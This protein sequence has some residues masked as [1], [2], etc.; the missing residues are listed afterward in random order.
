MFAEYLNNVYDGR[1]EIPTNSGSFFSLSKGVVS[2]PP[3]V[4]AREAPVAR[5]SHNTR[6][7]SKAR[8]RY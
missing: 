3:C 8:I 7:E 2:S 5:T 1:L 6:L 4:L